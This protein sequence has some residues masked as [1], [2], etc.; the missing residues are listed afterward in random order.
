MGQGIFTGI[1]FKQ[2][3][4]RARRTML[5]MN[6]KSLC[7]TVLTFKNDENNDDTARSCPLQTSILNTLIIIQYKLRGETIKGVRGGGNDSVTR[8]VCILIIPTD[9]PRY[10]KATGL[11]TCR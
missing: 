5:N 2:N 1:A 4:I 6:N 10:S 11:Y 7:R 3:K 9:A 8:L